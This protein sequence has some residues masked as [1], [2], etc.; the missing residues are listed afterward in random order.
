M[1]IVTPRYTIIE[2]GAI[3]KIE[4][5]LKKLNLKNPLVITGKN[6]KNTV[7]FSMIL[8]IMMKF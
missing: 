6:T 4:E 2:D 1:I 7:D 8:Y 3:N 5:I